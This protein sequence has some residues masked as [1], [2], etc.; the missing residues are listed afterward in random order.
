MSS[1]KN[2]QSG[3]CDRGVINLCADYDA[4][5]ATAP[6]HAKEITKLHNPLFPKEASPPCFRETRLQICPQRR[7]AGLDLR[8]NAP[9]YAVIADSVL[10]PALS[11]IG[12]VEQHRH[13]AI[14]R[15]GKMGLGSLVALKFAPQRKQ[16]RAL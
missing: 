3:A 15:V 4:E 5:P 11:A 6:A 9:H 14:N 16:H 13:G 10:A 7:T 2:R 8:G 12:Q 1:G